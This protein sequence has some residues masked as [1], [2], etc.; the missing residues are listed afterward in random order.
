MPRAKDSLKVDIKQS[1]DGEARIVVVTL[2]APAKDFLLPDLLSDQGAISSYEVALREAVK[3]ATEGYLQGAKDVVAAITE[4]KQGRQESAP[5][6]APKESDVGKSARPKPG[7][8]PEEA[9]SASVLR[10]APDR[11]NGPVSA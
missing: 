2:T 3:R 7:S 5:A 10:N 9:T 6:R 8:K 4:R 1:T 11:A